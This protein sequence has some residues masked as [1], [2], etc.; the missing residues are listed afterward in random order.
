MKFSTKQR[1]RSLLI[2]PVI[3]VFAPQASGQNGSLLHAPLP[4]RTLAPPQPILPGQTQLSPVAALPAAAPQG[5]ATIDLPAPT[6]PSAGANP[7]GVVQAAGQ[8]SL[9]RPPIYLN[10]ASW[11]HQ[12]APP[13]RVFRKNDVVTIRVDEITRVMAEGSAETRKRTLYQAILTD[14]I[15]LTEFRLRPDTQANGDPSV[16]TESNNN[17]RL[18]KIKSSLYISR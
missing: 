6:A 4:Q 17:Y 12:P 15:R 5:I 11:T 9:D 13:L 18:I 7:T 8:G 2:I 3:L 14:W 16:G 10:G 1:S